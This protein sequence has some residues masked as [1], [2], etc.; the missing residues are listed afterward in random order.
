MSENCLRNN[1][2]REQRC[3]VRIASCLWTP[4]T[5]CQP[6]CVIYARPYSPRYSRFSVGHPGSLL[7]LCLSG[8]SLCMG[9]VKHMR[10][11][12]SSSKGGKQPAGTSPTE[13]CERFFR[14]ELV[15]RIRCESEQ[16][17]DTFHAV[18]CEGHQHSVQYMRRSLL[19]L[20]V[21]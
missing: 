14:R 3:Q 10:N 21:S 18:R 11:A 6:L 2:Q 9:F 16:H 4:Q 7:E 13:L 1:Q 17:V 5:V 8:E 19:K 15:L 20:L 12:V